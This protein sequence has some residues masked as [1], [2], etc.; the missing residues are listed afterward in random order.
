MC[1][2][3]WSIRCA[4]PNG[5]QPP[6]SASRGP[7]GYRARPRRAPI[8]S[9]R[10][11]RRWNAPVHRP[12]APGCSHPWRARTCFAGVTRGPSRSH[13]AAID[14]ARSTDAALA[15]AHAMSTL[16]TSLTL[17]GRCADGTSVSR[18]AFA[19]NLADG[20][21]DSIGRAH[22]NYSSVLLICGAFEKSIE[23]AEAGVAWA[24]SAGAYEQYGRFHRRER[25]RRP[26]RAGPLGCR[27]GD[28]RRP[29]GR[30]RVRR[31]SSRHPRRCRHV[32]RAA[33]SCG[34]RPAAPG[35]GPRAR[36]VDAGCPVHRAHPPWPCRAGVDR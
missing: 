7:H 14:L 22:A 13:E 20:D 8:S 24:R 11:R 25:R 33:R 29:S 30:G 12:N 2:S 19:R 26:D 5:G 4:N 28:D 32:P 9:K 17:I 31:D 23:V 34:R 6:T 18:E 35:R 1:R 27:G 36:G 21:V 10:R 15:E 3:D 16:G